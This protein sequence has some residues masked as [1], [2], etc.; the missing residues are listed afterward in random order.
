AVTVPPIGIANRPVDSPVLEFFGT[1]GVGHE[2]AL[3][4]S[5]HTVVLGTARLEL[6]SEAHWQADC[7][8]SALRPP[9]ADVPVRPARPNALHLYVAHRAPPVPCVGSLDNRL[10]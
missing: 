4:L 2:P 3:E 5:D 9:P 1:G 7:R 8:L 6:E 10:G